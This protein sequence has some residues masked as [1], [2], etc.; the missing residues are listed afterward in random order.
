MA[1][2]TF[3]NN[4]SRPAPLPAWDV[5]VTGALGPAPIVYR[6]HAANEMMALSSALERAHNDPRIFHVLRT[7]RPVRAALQDDEPPL[8]A[9]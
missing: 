8:P 4:Y 9:A 7:E 2:K 6:V 5:E 1:R 3:N